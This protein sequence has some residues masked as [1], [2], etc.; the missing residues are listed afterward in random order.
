MVISDP[1]SY[2]TNIGIL[3]TGDDKHPDAPLTVELPTHSSRPVNGSMYNGIRAKTS[4]VLSTELTAEVRNTPWSW[5]SAA[6][7]R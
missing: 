2:N 4:G 3:K 5:T 6:A 1:Y 7:H